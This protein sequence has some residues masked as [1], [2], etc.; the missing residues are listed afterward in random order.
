MSASKSVAEHYLKLSY[1]CVDDLLSNTNN[2]IQ[3]KLLNILKA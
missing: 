3:L 1:V 2:K